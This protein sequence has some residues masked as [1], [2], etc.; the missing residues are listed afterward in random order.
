MPTTNKMVGSTTVMTSTAFPVATMMPSVQR[1]LIKTTVK[2]TNTPQTV[3]KANHKNA[4]NNTMP[5]LMNHA[6]SRSMTP[7]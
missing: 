1:P 4:T 6:T 2:G 5:T 7:T 3:R